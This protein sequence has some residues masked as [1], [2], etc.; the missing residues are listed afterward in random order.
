V[1]NKNWQTFDKKLWKR[2]YHEHIIREEQSYIKIS[3]YIINN[4][5]HWDNESL[6]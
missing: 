1:K 4:P 2:N 3:E 5:A 6:K